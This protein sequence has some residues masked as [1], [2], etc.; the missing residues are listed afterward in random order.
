MLFGAL[1]RRRRS[2]QAAFLVLVFIGFD[3]HTYGIA[4]VAEREKL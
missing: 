3:E 1:A 2:F 4:S